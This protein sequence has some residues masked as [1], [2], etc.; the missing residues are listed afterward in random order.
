MKRYF[1]LTATLFLLLAAAKA[2]AQMP[3]DAQS[4]PWFGPTYNGQTNYPAPAT[5][6]V[7]APAATP[8]S[9]SYC[10]WSDPVICENIRQQLV[11]RYNT[12]NDWGYFKIKK[13]PAKFAKKIQVFRV[14]PDDSEQF[15]VSADLVDNWWDKD[16]LIPVKTK[17]LR[18]KYIDERYNAIVDLP[19]QIIPDHVGRDLGK[20]SKLTISLTE[21][22]FN[23]ADFM[24][25]NLHH[26]LV[27]NPDGSHTEFV[28]TKDG[29]LLSAGELKKQEIAALETRLAE[30]KKK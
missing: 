16:Q 22:H 24:R 2:S 1:L 11:R 21:N 27:E 5:P 3:V 29:E 30:L 9:Y 17:A 25:A 10:Y 28:R 8:S 14:L 13:I 6:A 15:V 4:E 26:Q 23:N 7:T 18:F 19:V 20:S 12:G